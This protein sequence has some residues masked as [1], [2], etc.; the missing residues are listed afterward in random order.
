MAFLLPQE[1]N[2]IFNI[3]GENGVPYVPK[4]GTYEVTQRDLLL[5]GRV[6]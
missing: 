4:E 5:D 1:D 6:I 2:V 3:M